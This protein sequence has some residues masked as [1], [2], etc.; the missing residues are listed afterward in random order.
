MYLAVNKVHE[1]GLGVHTH[2]MIKFATIASR[3]TKRETAFKRHVECS[4]VN[5]ST[6]RKGKTGT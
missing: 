3:R 6:L 2:E 4:P 5:E 1:R